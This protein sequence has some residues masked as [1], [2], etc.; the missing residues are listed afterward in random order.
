MTVNGTRVGFVAS[1]SPGNVVNIS[2]LAKYNTYPQLNLPSCYLLLR[3][4]PLMLKHRQLENQEHSFPSLYFL[5]SLLQ[6]YP[7]WEITVE[8]IKSGG[9][10]ATFLSA[11]ANEYITSNRPLYHSQMSH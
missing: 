9:L 10:R 4:G 11:V 2:L 1:L 6:Y 7:Q 3:N 8:A 5:L